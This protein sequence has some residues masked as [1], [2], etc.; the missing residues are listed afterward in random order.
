MQGL[1]DFDAAWSG[2]CSLRLF[3]RLSSL[4]Q[5]K[6]ADRNPNH[7]CAL[8]GAWSRWAYPIPGP[9]GLSSRL[10]TLAFQFSTT[11]W[12]SKK[13][14]ITQLTA[15]VANEQCPCDTRSLIGKR[16][17]HDARGF[18][19]KK[20]RCPLSA[21]ILRS[22]ETNDSGSAYNKQPSNI[23]VPLFADAA[24]PFLAAAAMRPWR[25]TQPCRKLPTGPE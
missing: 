22:R 19:G 6:S 2:T 3:V 21:W 18:A 23:A 12:G 13:S 9:T 15:L 17:R 10:S 1:F 8:C 11:T 14:P 20:R 4:A 7:L 5:M 25:Q 24:L 16:N